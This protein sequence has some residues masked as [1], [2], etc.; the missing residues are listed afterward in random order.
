MRSATSRFRIPARRRE[1][2]GRH[3]I[4]RK[5]RGDLDNILLLAMRKEPKPPIRVG[6]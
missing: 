5:L 6:A 1:P 2:E 3:I 4:V